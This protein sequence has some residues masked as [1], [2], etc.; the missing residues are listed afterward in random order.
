MTEVCYLLETYCLCYRGIDI[1][2]LSWKPLEI[3]IRLRCMIRTWSFTIA[4][5]RLLYTLWNTRD[6]NSLTLFVCIGSPFAGR[7]CTFYTT[8][9]VLCYYVHAIYQSMSLS[10]FILL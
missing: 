2:T 9:D 10:C 5:L 8:R 1:R 3:S 7:L 4:I 6:P